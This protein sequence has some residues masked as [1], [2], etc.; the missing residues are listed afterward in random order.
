MKDINTVTIVEKG[1]FNNQQGDFM[2]KV[3]MSDG[4]T[5]HFNKTQDTW[6]KISL[7]AVEVLE[8]FKKNPDVKKYYG[9]V[10]AEP[11]VEAL[12]EEPKVK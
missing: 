2:E 8:N 12:S 3:V 6:K 1:E 9:V 10:D 7:D 5:W 11:V 4:T